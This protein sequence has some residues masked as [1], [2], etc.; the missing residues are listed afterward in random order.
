MSVS[1][2][3]ILTLITFGLLILLSQAVN[4]A[5]RGELQVQPIGDRQLEVKDAH[6]KPATNQEA[7]LQWAR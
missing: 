6:S 7:R 2:S 4:T 3:I 5:V 1:K